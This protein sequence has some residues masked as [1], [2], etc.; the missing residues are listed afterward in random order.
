MN[1]WT[2]AFRLARRELRG[3]TKGFRIFLACLILGVATIAAV[4]SL[5]QSISAG[6]QR[7]GRSLLGGD[8]DLRLSSREI[9]DTQ[10]SFIESKSTLSHISELRAM[11]NSSQDRRLIEL[12]AVDDLYP[13]VGSMDLSPKIDLKTALE[14]H[15]ALVEKGL[16]ERLKIQIGDSVQIGKATFV[17]RAVISKEPDRIASVINFGPRVLISMDALMDTELV[18]PGSVIQHHYR[19]MLNT[20]EA[21]QTFAD[22]LKEKFPE[23]GWRIQTS[24]KAAPGIENF[25]E[26]LALFLS[27]VGF[28]TLLIGGV[29][30]SAGVRDYLDGKIA[31]IATLKCLGAPS[32]VIFRT[33]LVQIMLLS[34]IGTSIGLVIGASA[35]YLANL[36]PAS[37]FPVRP[38]SELYPLALISAAGFGLLTTLTFALWPLG[39]SQNVPAS[40]LFRDKIT[41]IEAEPSL[42][43]KIYSY[44]SAVSLVILTLISAYKLDFAVIFIIAALLTLGLLK[45]AGK[46]TLFLAKK[47]PHSQNTALRLAITSLHRPGTTAPAV[48]L[49][50]GLGLSVLVAVSLIN[51][52]LRSQIS[53][54]IPK[55]APAFFFIDIQNDQILDFDKTLTSI[56]G[57]QNYKRV[58]SLRGRIVEINGVDVEKA[59]IDPESQWAVRG[60]RALTYASEP[61][62]GS[63]ITKGTWWPADYKGK[64]LISLDAG[65]AHGFGVDIGDSLTVNV[66]GRNVTAEITS[67]REINWKSMRFDFAIIMSPGLLEYA[68]HSHIGAIHADVAAEPLIES[69]IAKDFPNVSVLRVKEALDSARTIMEGISSA[70]AAAASLTVLAGALVLSGAM[71]A[72]RERR[73]YEAIIFKVLG[74]TRKRMLFAYLIEYGLLGILTGIISAGLGTLSSWGVIT[75]VM[76]MDWS[77]YPQ[78]IVMTLCLSLI[79]TLSAGFFGTWRALGQKAAKHLRNE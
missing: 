48:I 46:L 6:L 20:G 56:T 34:F 37:F 58:P 35:P 33:Y 11:A 15:G 21:V 52:N 63:K 31:T 40:A 70:I 12:K 64:P 3:G 27:F 2:H 17:V 42:K 23:A 8:I 36:L 44:T 67:L 61:S 76:K 4:S 72:G 73:T 59:V 69:A 28:T 62:E 32:E 19:L 43:F 29:G 78:T 9:T 26:R 53:D 45:L 60:D 25:I 54:E 10:R 79:L 7:D 24:D 38:A 75:Y 18:Q 14:N 50:L 51:E 55:Q 5:N 77:F 39:R 66:L 41:P 71:A 74:A 47:A 57:T 65:L 13:L 1:A 30:V 22:L 49:S 68:P 16:L